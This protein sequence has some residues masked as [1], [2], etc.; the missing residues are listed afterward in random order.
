MPLFALPLFLSGL[1][2]P[3]F[4]SPSELPHTPGIFPPT[5]SSGSNPEEGATCWV[6][7]TLLG[8]Q[9]PSAPPSLLGQG[10]QPGSG[11]RRGRRRAPLPGQHKVSAQYSCPD[12]PKP[13]DP[14]QGMSALPGVSCHKL[15]P[16]PGGLLQPCCAHPEAQ[17]LLLRL[18]WGTFLPSWDAI[19]AR[20]S[21]LPGAEGAP[22]PCRLWGHSCSRSTLPAAPGPCGQG[23]VPR[24]GIPIPRDV[25]GTGWEAPAEL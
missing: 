23:R 11:T 14:Q 20:H 21:L 22:G 6:P 12:Q 19:P 13:L 1:L 7:G 16:H 4:S 3:S 10:T 15:S 25:P 24:A 8:T 17:K 9:S 5:G 18:H 2:M